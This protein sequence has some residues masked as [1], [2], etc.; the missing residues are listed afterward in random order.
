[1]PT[2]SLPA[3]HPDGRR[4]GAAWVAATGAFLLLASATVFIAVRW[5]QLPEAA[6]LALVGALTGAFLAGGR[7]IRRTL[8]ATGD[9]L[10]HLGAF[11]VPVDVAGL[12]LRLH[13]GWRT[14]LLTEG[15]VSVVVLGALAAVA[16]SVVL[17]WG[18]ATAAV[19]L[20]AGTASVTPL[21][22]PMILALL[23]VG[24]SILGRRSVAVA[25][26]SV[27][28]LAPVV[29]A[30]A[31]G[32]LETGAGT[33]VAVMEE[34]GLGGRPAALVAVASSPLAAIVLGREAARRRDLGLV[35]LAGTCLAT[36]AATTWVN[37][38]PPR[39]VDLLAAPALLL[40]VEAIVMLTQ[41]DSFWGRPARAL[42]LIAETVAAAVGAPI[43]AAFLLAAPFV[44]GES[45]FLSVG[46]G[47]TPQPAAA[48]A[49][50]LVASAWLL[51]GWRRQGPQ[52]SPLAALRWA[53]GDDR[54]VAF[55]AAAAGAA[56]VVGTVSTVA[57]AAGL[58]VLGAGLLLGAADPGRSR[59]ALAT[60]L[61][62]AA[63][64]WAVVVV[65]PTHPLAALPAA[66]VGAATIGAAAM[67]WRRTASGAVAA[68]LGTAGSLIALL[69]C[70]IAQ[71]QIG[72]VAAMVTAVVAAWALAAAIERTS[73]LA[74]HLVRGT[75][76]LGVIG[77]TAGSSTQL[78]LV[79]GVATLLFALDAA[80][81]DEPLIALGSALGVPL[82]VGTACAA[83][84]VSV[85][86]T[87]LI[88]CASAAV[89]TGLAT[90]YPPRW[91]LPYVV[92][93]AVAL[94]A[95]LPMAAYEPARLAEGLLVIGGLIVVAGVVTRNG[96]V[97]H[98]GGAVALVGLGLH[99]TVDGVTAAE[100]FVAPVA[101]QLVVAGWQL[102]RRA[103]PPSSWTTFGPAIGLLGAAALSERLAGGGA[104]HSLI[105]GAVGVAAVAAGGWWR[106]AGPLF[107]G[108]GLLV[109]VTTLESLGML[110]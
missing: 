27:A 47:W 51:A 88:L 35:A 102:R 110:A 60:I 74:G 28:G 36:G 107:L 7:A 38:A 13:L 11:L 103:D 53:A 23:A 44:D 78:L 21:P 32:L 20:A 65:G 91:R 52:A 8:P 77:A 67:T 75:I 10:F 84:G 15:V 92:A 90:C 80:R 39:Q 98:A 1:M 61:G 29:G 99:L 72:V 14:L 16:G 57:V 18:A 17:R 25:W 50:A 108:T 64:A 96:I 58:L 24:A 19:A 42:G 97:G 55:L 105:A 37:V 62:L 69:G 48:L 30:L 87:G 9:V 54:T 94:I 63:V 70:G 83:A 3:N 12:S 6:K 109:A 71:D 31:A 89:C 22:A 68:R 76:A 81:H 86:S 85:A 59:G 26:A 79:A 104:W 45:E 5:D 33:G 2:T 34:L 93:A 66:L 95:G 73:P 4:A 43:A 82:L 106:L 46:R 56:L 41:G 101:L 40:L 49:W 100:A